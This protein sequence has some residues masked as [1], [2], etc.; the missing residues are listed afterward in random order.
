LGHWFAR[1]P[2]DF[3]KWMLEPIDDPLKMGKAGEQPGRIR[4]A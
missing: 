3:A 4:S 1:L 2:C